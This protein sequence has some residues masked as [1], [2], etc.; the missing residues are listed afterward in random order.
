M[1][2]LIRT[3]GLA[4]VAL[5]VIAVGAS[6]AFASPGFEVEGASFPVKFT[7]KSTEAGKLI[8]GSEEVVCATSESTGN[9]TKSAVEGVEITYH[10]CEG[11]LFGIPGGECQNQGSS[12][13]AIKTNPLK[14][15]PVDVS[16]YASGIGLEFSASSDL[17][18]FTC[19]GT[20][21][22]VHKITGKIICESKPANVFSTTG[23]I[24]CDV[25][26][27]NQVPATPHLEDNGTAATQETEEEIKYPAGVKI[28]QTS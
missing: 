4:L 23:T 1:K 17:T 7:G 18:D 14:G 21:S 13:K 8:S 19:V 26:G 27:G 22:T 9:V 24:D 2:H 28:K 6:A 20:G 11:K 25:S 12:T 15:L 3:L 16:G 10:N 5:A